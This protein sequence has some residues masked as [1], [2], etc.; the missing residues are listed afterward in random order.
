MAS[1]TVKQ[2]V[3]APVERVFDLASDFAGCPK[4]INGIKKIEMLTPG[5]VGVGTRFKET[6]IMFKKEATET[7]EV[8][9]WDPPRGY[10]LG[11]ESCGATIRSDLRFLSKDGGTRIEMTTSWTANSFFAKL[12]SPLGALMAGSMKKMVQKD[13]DDL[14]ASIERQG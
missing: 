12:M 13:L 11:A 9:A 5:P 14:A 10:A 2:H 3:N 7:M 1:F 6:R 8:V 4:F